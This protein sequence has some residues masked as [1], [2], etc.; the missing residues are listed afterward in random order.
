MIPWKITRAAP[1]G[2]AFAFRRAVMES[3]AETQEILETLS[4]FLRGEVEGAGARERLRAAELLGK[5]HGLFDGDQDAAAGP[6]VIEG[7]KLLE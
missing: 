7:G 5:R 6:V 4:A 2:A 1:N 3:V